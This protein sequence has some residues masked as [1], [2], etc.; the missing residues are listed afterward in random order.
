MLHDTR[1]CVCVHILCICGTDS[2]CVAN[3][4]LLQLQCRCLLLLFI[5]C[6]MA[7]FVAV[8]YCTFITRFI[9]NVPLGCTVA[10]A[11]SLTYTPMLTPHVMLPRKLRACAEPRRAAARCGEALVDTYVF[12][13]AAVCMLGA[14][15]VLLQSG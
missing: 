13:M 15:L 9:F 11:A 1:I 8:V 12:Q 4:V 3:L 14:V 10:C 5:V 2:L 7:H 6:R